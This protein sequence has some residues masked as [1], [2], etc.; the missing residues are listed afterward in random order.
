MLSGWVRKITDTKLAAGCPSRPGGGWG[1]SL[2]IFLWGL[3]FEFTR[4]FSVSWRV[5]GRQW[6]CWVARCRSHRPLLSGYDDI[7][8]FYQQI[9][10]FGP[11]GADARHYHPEYHP[12]L[13]AEL[14]KSSF[15]TFICL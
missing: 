1:G 6:P 3:A 10:L 14:Q 8:T 7:Q 2:P 11:I 9:T 4:M 5:S 13:R 15:T 12:L